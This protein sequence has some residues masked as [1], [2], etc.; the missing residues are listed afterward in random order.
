MII[1]AVVMV[2][3]A[4]VLIAKAVKRGKGDRAREVGI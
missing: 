2:F 3:F 4:P 1:G